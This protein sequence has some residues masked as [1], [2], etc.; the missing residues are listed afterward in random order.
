MDHIFGIGLFFGPGKVLFPFSI[1]VWWF[2]TCPR[3]SHLCVGSRALDESCCASLSGHHTK[4]FFEECVSLHAPV[5]HTQCIFVMRW[6]NSIP[7]EDHIRAL[8]PLSL[9]DDDHGHSL[10]PVF[11]RPFYIIRTRMRRVAKAAAARSLKSTVVA[12][13]ALLFSTNLSAPSFIHFC[14]I[15]HYKSFELAT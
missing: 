1:L 10:H 7:S 8:L 9:K 5:L 3:Y 15:N 4:V 11:L 6:Y 2:I 13:Q 14:S 12:S